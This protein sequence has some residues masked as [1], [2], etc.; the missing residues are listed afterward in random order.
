VA[1][2]S[3][4]A[5]EERGQRLG[6]GWI[7]WFVAAL[8]VAVLVA[9]G[10]TPSGY[11][12]EKPGPVFDTLGTVEMDG[13]PVPLVDIPREATFPTTGSLSM[14]TVTTVGT[15]PERQPGCPLSPR[16]STRARRRFRSTTSTHP[17]ARRQ[18]RRRSARRR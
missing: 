4:Y 8:L 11:V 10:S 1:N 15:A 5:A 14:L 2:Y 6:R 18:R 9:F 7:T 17:A 12:I 16:G 13:E 3:D